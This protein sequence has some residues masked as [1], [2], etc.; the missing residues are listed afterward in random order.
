MVDRTSTMSTDS[1]QVYRAR[2]D[3]LYQSIA[4]YAITFVL[5]LIIRSFGVTGTFPTLWQ[6]PLLLM[7]SIITVISVFAL[8]YNIFLHRQIE[9]TSD[10]IRFTSRVRKRSI[11]KRNV[12]YVQFGSRRLPNNR[13]GIRVVRI[14]IKGRKR[15][16][17]IRLGYF[18][19]GKALLAD[20]REWAG[21][22]AKTGRSKAITRRTSNVSSFGTHA[23]TSAS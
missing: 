4:V 14:G 16:A 5:Y 6:D 13:R 10:A 9:I 20:L 8:V 12:T 11:E 19:N 22:L 23:E 15:P 17:R 1:K 3:F 7:L 18:E 21:P 2:L